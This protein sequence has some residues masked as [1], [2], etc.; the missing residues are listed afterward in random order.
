MLAAVHRRIGILPVRH[1]TVLADEAAVQDFLG[2]RCEDLLSDL[3]PLEET[4]EIGLRIE[5]PG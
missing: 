5:L 1:E 2:N 4:S 3:D